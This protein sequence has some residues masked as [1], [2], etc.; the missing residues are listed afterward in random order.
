MFLQFLYALSDREAE[1][2]GKLHLVC[3]WFAE[4]QSEEAAPDHSTI[5]RFRSR[6]GPR[7]FGRF[8]TTL[9][10]EHTRSGW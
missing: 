1:E 5:S 7:N 10:A 6:L 3:E 8:S 9:S 4:L 2:Q